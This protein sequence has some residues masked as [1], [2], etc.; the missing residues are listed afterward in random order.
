LP[1]KRKCEA[2]PLDS[3]HSAGVSA[4]YQAVPKTFGRGLDIVSSAT[5]S[6]ACAGSLRCLAGRLP[7]SSPPRESFR[8][9]ARRT[10]EAWA[11]EGTDEPLWNGWVDPGLR[12]RHP[13]WPEPPGRDCGDSRPMRLTNNSFAPPAT[14]SRAVRDQ[15]TLQLS[16]CVAR[17]GSELAF[18]ARRRLGVAGAPRN[19]A[20]DPVR[21]VGAQ[22]PPPTLH[23]KSGGKVGEPTTWRGA[24]KR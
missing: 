9:A 16:R 21:R 11:G 6:V 13:V 7:Q 14:G 2:A 19:V 18:G 23:H 24:E 12:R 5:R 4:T 1:K 3:R 8:A 10:P 20:D 15:A 17:I 22:R